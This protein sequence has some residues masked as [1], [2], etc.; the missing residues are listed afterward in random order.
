MSFNYGNKIVTNG[1]VMYLDAANP[2]SYTSG[3]TTWNDLSGNTNNGTLTGGATGSIG[4]IGFDG[5]DDRVSKAS[6]IDVG[7][8]FS[9]SAWIYPTL[10]GI[11]R[12]CI[13]SN[14]YNYSIRNGWLLSIGGASQLN[15]F[16]LSIGADAAYKVGPT[17]ALSLN[18]WAYITGV[19][20][21]GGGVIDLYK[22]GNILSYTVYSPFNGAITYTNPQFNIGYRDITGT[23][24]PYTGNIA[25]V[26]LYNRSLS[27]AE[28][29]QNYNATKTRFGL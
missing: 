6:N 16:Y 25:S 3:S 11:T 5:V 20:T 9:I 14:S 23:T 18:T 27:A 24:D 10:L 2:N 26:S 19:V 22:N 1:L 7:V 8:N 12:R 4:Y 13:T 15:T 29:L 28:V 17:N 21:N